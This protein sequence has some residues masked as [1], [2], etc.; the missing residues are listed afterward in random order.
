MNF[1]TEIRSHDISIDQRIASL[2]YEFRQLISD[3]ILEDKLGE[4]KWWE[5]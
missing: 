1:K 4:A 2:C 5:Y 3:M